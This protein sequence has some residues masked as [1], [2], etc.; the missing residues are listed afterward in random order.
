MLYCCCCC[1]WWWRDPSFCT[2][3]YS[4]S[5]IDLPPFD[6][7]KSNVLMMRCSSRHLSILSIFL[8]I[9]WT[10]FC[11]F[12]RR[13][14]SSERSCSFWRRFF[15]QTMTTQ[16]TM[17]IKGTAVDMVAIMTICAT[18]REASDD[19]PLLNREALPS[20]VGA[21]ELLLFLGRSHRRPEYPRGQRHLNSL[22][23]SMQVP[24][25]RQGRVAH[26]LTS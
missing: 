19:G 3:V 4:G 15:K 22:M 13:A 1:W 26:S 5:L 10:T 8:L 2:A 24:P 20:T 16:E 14:S 23:R 9:E 11:S 6:D 17:A 7:G 25:L 12:W 18:E 21:V